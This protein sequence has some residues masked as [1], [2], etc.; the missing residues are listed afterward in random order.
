MKW[1]KWVRNVFAPVIN[2]FDIRFREFEPLDGPVSPFVEKGEVKQ[3]IP[4][5]CINQKHIQPYGFVFR[6]SF[7]FT[8]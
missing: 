1:K 6:F 3:S 2:S 5:G 4:Y 7:F 8:L